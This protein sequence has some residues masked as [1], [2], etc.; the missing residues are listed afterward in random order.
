MR[1]SSLP[2]KMIRIDKA[3]QSIEYMLQSAERWNKDGKPTTEQFW[4]IKRKLAEIRNAAQAGTTLD[5]PIWD[6]NGDDLKHPEP[7]GSE[8]YGG[9]EGFDAD[10]AGLEASLDPNLPPTVLGDNDDAPF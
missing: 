10:A 9:G 1:R 6:E 3:A 7:D 8:N 4:Y 2:D 5:A